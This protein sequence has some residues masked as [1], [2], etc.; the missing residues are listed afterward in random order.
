MPTRI[1]QRIH[2][3]IDSANLLSH[4]FYVRWEEGNLEEGEL[5]SYAEQYRFF[6]AYLPRV[7]EDIIAKLPPCDAR[8]LLEQNLADELG[9]PEPHL[10]MFNKFARAVG[11][12]SQDEV[13]ASPAMRDLI[14]VYENAASYGPANALGAL[15]YY[16]IQ[17]ADIA[18]SKAKGLLNNYNLSEVEV[19]FWTHHAEIE[20]DHAEWTIQAIDNVV[21]DDMESATIDFAQRASSVWWEFLDE[22][23]AMRPG[24]VRGAGTVLQ[25]GG[26]PVV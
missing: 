20:R 4:P 12:R 16:E 9:N 14:E 1:C 21:F 25:G 11:A 13:M 22:R 18:Q 15:S 19:E 7:L 3:V 17:S 5:A 10:D 23:E 6:E 26:S 8:S 2:D 24:A